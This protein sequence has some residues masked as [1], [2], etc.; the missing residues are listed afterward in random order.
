[1]IIGIKF[2]WRCKMKKIIVYGL[3][4]SMSLSGEEVRRAIRLNV[5]NQDDSWLIHDLELGEYE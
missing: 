4:L 2:T 3:A 1:M 5:K